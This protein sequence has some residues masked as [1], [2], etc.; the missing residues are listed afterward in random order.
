VR[1]R[2]VWGSRRVAFVAGL[3]KAMS[4]VAVRRA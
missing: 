1:P 3:T 4:K 2:L